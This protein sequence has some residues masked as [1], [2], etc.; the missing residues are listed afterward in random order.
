MSK[1][2]ARKI[3]QHLFCR[4][5]K[6]TNPIELCCFVHQSQRA[7]KTAKYASKIVR[8]PHH[9]T[10]T[11]AGNV[12]RKQVTLQTDQKRQTVLCVKMCIASL[13]GAS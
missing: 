6:L 13:E 8:S 1:C 3:D 10:A 12:E 11:K 7:K 2:F 4:G 9:L 5:H